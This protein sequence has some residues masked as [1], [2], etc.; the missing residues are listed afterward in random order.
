MQPKT[1]A[2]V[3]IAAATFLVTGPADAALTA[4]TTQGFNTVIGGNARTIWRVYAQFDNPNDQ[5]VSMGPIGTD[6]MLITFAG[7]DPGN[8]PSG[9]FF[10]GENPT[11]PEPDDLA[12]AL[13]S[14]YAINNPW[15]HPAPTYINMP[16]IAGNLVFA[17]A[18]SGGV[19]AD[20]SMPYT[21][22]GYNGPN[23]RILLLQLQVTGG[24][25]VRGTLGID[26]IPAGSGLLIPVTVVFNSVPAPGPL[27]LLAIGIAFRSRR[28]RT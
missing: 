10:A 3:L 26:Y 18:G 23:N 5:I 19:F 15:P 27:A 28:R 12:G 25:H 8:P 21:F 14:F 9:S 11:P 2:T 4:V 13:R 7:P 20:P 1:L 6:V 16:P 22:A 17:A 24:N